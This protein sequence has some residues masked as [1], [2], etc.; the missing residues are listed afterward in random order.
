MPAKAEL[1]FAG[2]AMQHQSQLDAALQVDG[3]YDYSGYFTQIAPYIKSADY[4]VVNLETPLG[5]KPYS[6][7]PMFCA[8]DSYAAELKQSGFDL[9]L[10]ANNHT[11]DRRDRGLI[12]TTTVLD[13]LGITH[14]GTYANKAERDKKLPLITEINGFKVAFLN[15][16]YGTN[17]IPVQGNVIVD[18]IDADLMKQDITSARRNGAEIVTVCLHWGDEY[19][20]LPNR[21]QRKIADMLADMGVELIIGSHPHVIQPMEL[22]YNEKTHK[23]V[24]SAYS[25]G[26]FISGMRT[27]DTRGGVMAKVTLT[28]DSLGKAVISAAAYLPVFAVPPK[29]GKTNYHLIPAHTSGPAGT[30]AWRKRFISNAMHIFLKHNI[31]VPADTAA[32]QSL[33]SLCAE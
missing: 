1:V 19:R 22:R 24:F 8:P 10:T 18:R 33:D 21:H 14:I 5:G 17:G 3:S 27:T 28:R 31:N 4:A 9:L 12:R 6:G 16:T 11:L 32:M 30:E 13:S 20:L 25:L 29:Y 26:N 2:D 23:N 15:Y 7:Y